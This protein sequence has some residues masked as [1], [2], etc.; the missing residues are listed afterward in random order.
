MGGNFYIPYILTW[1]YGIDGKIV[2]PEVKQNLYK[3][4]KAYAMPI[5]MIY[6]VY[7]YYIV[8]FQ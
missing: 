6:I 1:F 2:E 8:V 4:N 7:C 3:I 5:C